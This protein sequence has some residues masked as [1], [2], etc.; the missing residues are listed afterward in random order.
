MTKEIEAVPTDI[1]KLAED[2]SVLMKKTAKAH[3]DDAAESHRCLAA[4]LDRVRGLA[5]RRAKLANGRLRKQAFGASAISFG[6]GVALGL[7]VSRRHR[8][9][10]AFETALSGGI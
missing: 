10:G 4:G 7:L 5:V 2:A 8:V 1:H 9:D 6:I 3:E